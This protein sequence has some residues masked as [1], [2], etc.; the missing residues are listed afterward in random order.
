M[1][2]KSPA[3][4]RPRQLDAPNGGGSGRTFATALDAFF[5]RRFSLVAIVPSTQTLHFSIRRNGAYGQGPAAKERRIVGLLLDGASQKQIAFE[6][7]VS[8]ST[9]NVCVHGMLKKLEVKCTEHLVLLASAVGHLSEE[10]L[11]AMSRRA[12]SGEALEDGVDLAFEVAMDAAAMGELTSAEER[13]ALYVLEGRSNADIALLRGTS[14]R[15]VA[16]Q[17]A[18]VFRKLGASGRVELVRRL[19]AARIG[20]APLN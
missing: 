18:A 8:L 19:V 6:L 12:V 16:N 3:I 2:T 13:V 5:Q 1:Q 20:E 14:E 7:G 15:T 17:I 4:E 9:V 11:L 10:Q